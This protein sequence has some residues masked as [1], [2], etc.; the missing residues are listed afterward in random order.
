MPRVPPMITL[1]PTPYALD[2]DQFLPVSNMRF[3]R[4]DYCMKQPQKTLV[5]AKVLKYW[6]ENTQPPCLAEP[7]QLAEGAWELCQAME[8]LAT[9][10]DTEVLGDDPPSNWKFITLCRLT[11]LKQPDQGTQRERSHS[12]SQRAHARGN[13]TVACGMGHSKPTATTWAASPSPVPTQKVE[14]QQEKTSS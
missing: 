7:H 10:T 5:Y 12:R 4:K 8:P 2:C 14:S 13:F 1:Q 9:F 3:G 6:A 11:E